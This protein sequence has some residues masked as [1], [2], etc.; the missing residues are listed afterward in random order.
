MMC[1]AVPMGKT[2]IESTPPNDADGDPVTK[3][4]TGADA[5]WWTGR[6]GHTSLV[7]D[8]DGAGDRIWVLGGR[9]GTKKPQ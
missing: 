3:S 1:G 8:P 6:D 7:F 9:D 5:N 4:T 2:W